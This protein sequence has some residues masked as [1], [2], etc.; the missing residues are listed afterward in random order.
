LEQGS[1]DGLRLG[2]F[3]VGTNRRSLVG[4]IKDPVFA[5]NLA[6]V[7]VVGKGRNAEVGIVVHVDAGI[8]V[9]EVVAENTA[10]SGVPSAHLLLGY[11]DHLLG[12]RLLLFELD[13]QVVD[14]GYILFLLDRKVIHFA[15]ETLLDLA[16]LGHHTTLHFL[17]LFA[18]LLNLLLVMLLNLFD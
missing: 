17:V 9:L 1:V 18:D 3:I 8:V 5:L 16:H 4:I 7:V 2:Q 14:P 6:V 13:L 15:Q 12:A 11:F 10:L